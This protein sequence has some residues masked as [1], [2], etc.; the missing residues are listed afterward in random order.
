MA[1]E[2]IVAV[3]VGGTKAEAALVDADARL[4]PGTRFRAP[5]ATGSSR[6]QIA[7]AVILVVREATAALPTGA[8]LLGAGIGSA[9]P[10]DAARGTVSPLNLAT[11]QDYPLR[12]LV[13]EAS[14][15]PDPVLRL[16]G[17]CI[18]LAEH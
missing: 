14:G 6:E 17:L 9:G 7:D 12:D 10:I 5:T 13:A 4:V 15:L 11:F 2:F 18:L 16:D 8:R 1:E 3:D